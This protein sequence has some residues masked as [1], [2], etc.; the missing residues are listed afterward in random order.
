MR[1][2]WVRNKPLKPI[3]LSKKQKR[4]KKRAKL[5]NPNVARCRAL[6]D[7]FWIDFNRTEDGDERL[8]LLEMA[9]NPPWARVAKELRLKLRKEFRIRYKTLL[10]GIGEECGVC[11]NEWREKHH[12]VPLAYGGINENINLIAICLECHDA[13]HPWLKET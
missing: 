1:K 10:D 9:A 12:I 2:S 5:Q 11:P 7:R 13:I 3:R 8:Q 4:K 6:L